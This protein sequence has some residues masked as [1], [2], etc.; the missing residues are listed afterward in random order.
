MNKIKMT[1]NQQ[2]SN[3][4]TNNY[5]EEEK[6]YQEIQVTLRLKKNVAEVG[7]MMAKFQY[8]DSFDAFASYEM[9]LVIR[10]NADSDYPKEVQDYLKEENDDD[11]EEEM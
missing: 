9:D 11:E 10:G 3:N 2:I 4:N 7:K 1:S 8:N 6:E 5:T